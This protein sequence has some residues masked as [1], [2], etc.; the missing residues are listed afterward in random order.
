MLGRGCVTVDLL[1]LRWRGPHHVPQPLPDVGA[2]IDVLDIEGPH[3][4][5]SEPAEQGLQ[6]VA[7][8]AEVREQR[9]N[10]GICGQAVGDE[11][12][13][14]VKPPAGARRAD[15]EEPA[16]PVVRRGDGKTDL[17]AR[18]GREDVEIAKDAGHLVRMPTGPR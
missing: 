17:G 4:S 1:H 15:L 11:R 9:A 2:E 16:Q 7:L 8:V 3:A 6:C 10:E 18:K 13:E 5:T 14:R 12:C